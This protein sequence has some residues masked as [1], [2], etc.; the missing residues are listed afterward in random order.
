M[1]DV[2]GFEG[3]YAITSC[4]KVWSYK[5]K[6]W[7]AGWHNGAGYHLVRLRKNKKNYTKRVHVLVAEAYLGRPE[8]P[9]MTD[10]GHLDD[11][12]LNNNVNNLKWMTRS[13]N[14]DTDSFREKQSI[15]TFTKIRCVE[16]GEI[17]NS[18]RDAGRAVGIH[19][20]G[21]TCVL[22]GRQKTAGGYHWERTDEKQDYYIPAKI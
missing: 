9:M 12:R 15:K 1:R 5:S 21:I 22:M 7:V 14:L 20:Y 17:Y 16:T 3:L 6:K 8:D 18:Q 19:P 13:E 4:G 2:I 10:V 11:N